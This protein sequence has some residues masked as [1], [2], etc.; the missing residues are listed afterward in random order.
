MAERA[1][2]H[3]FEATP[4]GI[5]FARATDG[6]ASAVCVKGVSAEGLPVQIGDLVRSVNG[7]DTSELTLKE[8]FTKLKAQPLPLDIGFTSIVDAVSTIDAMPSE[9]HLRGLTREELSKKAIVNL[10][11]KHGTAEV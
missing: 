11:Q 5:S 10:L 6:A 8:L 2:T 3:R 7:E 1:F 9:K 4:F